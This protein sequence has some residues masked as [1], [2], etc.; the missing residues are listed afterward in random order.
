MIGFSMVFPLLSFYAQSMNATPFQIGLLAASHALANFLTSPFLGRISD[1]FGRRP[2]LL[3]G[4]FAGTLSMT[5]M[6]LANSLVI[7][8]VGR[9]AHGIVTSAILPTARAYTGDV[10]GG[11]QRIAAMGKLGAAMS[12]G[13]LVGPAFSSILVGFGNLH[14]PF[15]AAAI[16]CF[17]NAISV[18]LFLPESVTQKAEKIVVS[19]GLFNIF[20][21]FKH[22][23]GEMG[24]MFL[25]LFIWSFAMSN[26]QVAFPLL[27]EKK[28]NL[29]AS[30]IGYFFTALALVSIAVQG[31]LLTKIIKIFGEKR[32]LLFGLTIMGLSLL[33][34]PLA[35]TIALSLFAFM[36]M[37]LGS[38][39]NRPV[40]EGIVSRETLAGQGSTMGIAQSFES[41]GRMLGPALA[42]LLY[43][44]FAGAPFIFSSIL[45]VLTAVLA[46]TF[47]QIRQL[48]PAEV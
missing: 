18:L 6:G 3:I 12:A 37:G 38:N 1:K 7:L 27:E 34:L 5:L 4:L 44:F 21:I 46:L 19:E 32:T 26:N 31:F 20:S 16:I 33:I 47:L 24:L 30:H 11:H 9:V 10:T 40:A 23:K 36:G 39:L 45:L 35:S 43:G 29:G 8:L 28:F 13:L 25:I 2:I 42:G 41:L 14:T 17:I 15:F 22:L 48:K